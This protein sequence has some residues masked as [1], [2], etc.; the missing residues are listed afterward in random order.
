MSTNPKRLGKYELQERLGRG[1][2]GEVWKALDTQL[3]RYV[4]IKFL[5]SDLQNDPNFSA[6]FQREAQVIASLHHPNIVQLYDFQVSQPSTAE[7]AICYMVMN[8]VEGQT[9]AQHIRNMS[10]TGK[11]PSTTEIVPLFASISLAID[12]A[13]QKGMIHRDI[14]PSNIL[15][16]KNDTARNPMGEPI[17]S[18]FGIA[19]LLGTPT[20]TIGSWLGTPHY[21]SP[22]QSKGEPA[23]EQS[24]IYSLGVILYEICTGLLPFHGENTA[25]VIMQHINA[26]P[27]LPNYINPKVPSALTMVIMRSLAKNPIERFPTATA[28]TVAIANALNTSI[29]EW[30]HSTSSSMEIINKP[31]Y[32]EFIQPS[33]QLNISSQAAPS[34]M[35]RAY[36]STA[37]PTPL[38]NKLSST[39]PDNLPD[40]GSMMF[41]P[42]HPLPPS[43][44]SSQ[45]SLPPSFSSPQH[46]LP[47]SFSTPQHPLPPSFSSPQNSLPPSFSSPQNS[48]S[49]PFS[50]SQ[51]SLPPSFSSPQN[52]LS[53]PFSSSQH[54]LPTSSPSP[55]VPKTASYVMAQEYVRGENLEERLNRLHQPLAERDVLLYASQVLDKLE[56]MAQQTPPLVHGN[57]RPANIL[58]GDKDQRAHAVGS[59]DTVQWN[60]MPV[61]T[62]GYAPLEQLQGNGD[63][64]SDLYA[65]AATMHHLLT[66]RNPCNYPPFVYPLARMLNPHVSLEVERLLTYALT[67]DINQRYQSATKMKHDIDDIL[68]QLYGITNNTEALMSGMSGS[69]RAAGEVQRKNVIDLSPLTTR[70]TNHLQALRSQTQGASILASRPKPA[71]QRKGKR[72]RIILAAAAVLLLLL[73]GLPFALRSLSNGHSSQS[74]SGIPNSGIGVVKAPDGEYIGISN[75]SVAFDTKRADGDIKT[76]AATQ[77]KAGDSGSADALWQQATKIDTNDAEALIY[78][79]DR[80]VLDSGDPYITIIVGTTLTGSA[81]SVASGREATQAAY[82]AQKEYNT[83]SKLP[84]HMKVR[85]LIASSGN[86]ATYATTVAQQIVQLAQADKT[87]VAVMG[88]TST[89]TTLNA[90]GVLS[91][92]KI[93]M[94]TNSGADALTGRSRYFFRVTIPGS[95]QGAIG[96]QYAE[97]TLHAKKAVVFVDI[98]NDY[99][100]G[101]A[102]GFTNR[103]SNDGNTIIATE[104]YTIGNTTTLP[105]LL[106]DALSKHPDMIYFA[107]YPAEAGVLLA[108]MQSA[109]PPMLGGSALYQLG[110]FSTDAQKGLSHLHFTAFSYP[111]EWE[112]L[113]L[114]AKVPPFFADYQAAFDPNKK[115]ASY[116][117]SRPD[118]T[119]MEFYD[120]I[121]VLLYGCSIALAAKSPVTGSDV[122]QALTL[123]T[124]EKAFQGIT[125]QIAL[126]SDSNPVDRAVLMI[127]VTKDRFLKMD[128]IHGKF[129]IGEAERAGFNATSVCN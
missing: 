111:D 48:L 72:L 5:H 42:Q 51:N 102:N 106:Q 38:G 85:L 23:S 109:D 89:A 26:T 103:F 14:K 52:S 40:S 13:H 99:A 58:I 116:G 22:E 110:G 31:K 75:G 115:N 96:A 59:F 88:W 114:A 81:G 37:F 128:G 123:V 66:N 19:K 112:I 79:E 86:V 45:N 18:D 70:V 8:Y 108:H 44:S 11:Y 129:L 10:R 94:F 98:K 127:C 41:T 97:Q 20:V 9:L 57:I 55:L 93:P 113:G 29:P 91:A 117:Y 67:N 77:L 126:G 65:L 124:G 74:L 25:A 24:D 82:V 30:L 119:T 53:T 122:Q 1:G 84:A 15:L 35:Q 36:P 69:M 39:R 7:N 100:A 60:Q 121:S 76:Q 78:M 28:L 12:Y 64:R 107:G 43:F 62:P 6:R 27:T 73:A 90:I 125:S 34:P 101:L 54:P 71:Q 33:S 118:G 32:Q 120:A 16:D 17:L 80:R 56:E 49:T 61:T 104:S 87:V 92:A 95:S 63:P 83:A 47:P 4:A 50:S 2:M 3:H 105:G 46:P 21:T 68:L